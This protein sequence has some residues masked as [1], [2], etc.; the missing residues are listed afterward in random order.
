MMGYDFDQVTP[1]EVARFFG[2]SFAEKLFTLEAGYWQGPV[3]SGYGLHIV[4]ISEKT[5]S[6]MPELASVIEK[7]RTDWMFE[8]RQK[9]NKEIYERFK[10]R[11]EI[12][13]ED[14]PKQS[15]MAK[16]TVPDGKES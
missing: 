3:D 4:R 2:N 14:F 9:M 6:Q 8:Q 1:L 15:G 12:V 5:D 16:I 7:V 13:I 10:E 11:Y